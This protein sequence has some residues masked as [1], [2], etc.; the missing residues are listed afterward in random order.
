MGFLGHAIA[1][2]GHERLQRPLKS[3]AGMCI[4]GNQRVGVVERREALAA[5]Q[6]A[7][8]GGI[9]RAR[10]LSNNNRT[11]VFPNGKDR[12]TRYIRDHQGR[13]LISLSE[14]EAPATSFGMSDPR[15]LDIVFDYI[16]FFV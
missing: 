2:K 4:F 10:A 3:R 11:T 13:L 15:Y 5:E 1:S 8:P 6:S 12:C 7:T 16:I 14:Y 9:E